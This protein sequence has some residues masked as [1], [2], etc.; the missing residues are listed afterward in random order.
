MAINVAPQFCHCVL[1]KQFSI[2]VRLTRFGRHDDVNSCAGF[3][4]LWQLV[5]YN[6]GK[7]GSYFKQ[8][9]SDLRIWRDHVCYNYSSIHQRL[10]KSWVFAKAGIKCALPM[11]RRDVILG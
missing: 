10:G 6:H 3:Y 1:A 9:L 8:R 4:V 5:L 7:S 11:A 2:T